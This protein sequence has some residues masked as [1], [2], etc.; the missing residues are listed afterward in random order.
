MATLNNQMVIHQYVM[1]APFCSTKPC[2]FMF[3]VFLHVH[4]IAVD[5]RH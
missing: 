3:I 1:F 5:I 4:M 2:Y